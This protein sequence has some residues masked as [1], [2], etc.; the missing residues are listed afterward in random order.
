MVCD[1]TQL[2][3]YCYYYYY[4]Y[5]D[6]DDDYDYYHYYLLINVLF[7]NPI[8]IKMIFKGVLKSS[9]YGLKL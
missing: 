8:F 6:D 2:I 9:K 7:G 3:M 1:L 4:Y 5:Y